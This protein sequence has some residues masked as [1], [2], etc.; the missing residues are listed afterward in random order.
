MEA[1][2][3]IVIV[4][5]VVVL[6]VVAQLVYLRR[7]KAMISGGKIIKRDISFQE[8]AEIFTLSNAD[9]TIVIP[10]LKSMDISGTGVSWESKGG[11]KTVD[12]KSSH[13]WAARLTSLEGDGEKYRYCFQFTEW[14]TN[15]GVPWRQDTMNILLTSIEKAF[16]SIDPNTQV[17][18][19]RIK[20]KSKSS[21]L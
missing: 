19:E 7:N 12:F 21:F 5:V 9:F 2:I 15:K 14:Q 8:Y 10:A 3:I 18:T 16:L 17:V 6:V 4:A 13:E 1:I 20:T 11:T